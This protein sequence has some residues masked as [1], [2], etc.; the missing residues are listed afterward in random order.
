MFCDI[1]RKRQKLAAHIFINLL[2]VLLLFDLK[3]KLSEKIELMLRN[4]DAKVMKTEC[5]SESL[6]SGLN[7][8]KFITGI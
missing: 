7:H 1:F 6:Q 5:I 2:F 3:K 8:G 4:Q